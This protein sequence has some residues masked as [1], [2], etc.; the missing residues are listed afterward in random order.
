MTTSKIS[1]KGGISIANRSG[2][3]NLSGYNKLHVMS[4][5]NRLRKN[6]YVKIKIVA[7]FYLIIPENFKYNI[8]VTLIVFKTT[9]AK[10]WIININRI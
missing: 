8:D 5:V 1:I 4:K 9:L 10:F 6:M 2:N 3:I 7:S